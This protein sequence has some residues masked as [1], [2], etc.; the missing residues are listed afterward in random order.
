MTSIKFYNLK[1][2]YEEQKYDIMRAIHEVAIGGQYFADVSVS[3]FE[4]L[5]SKLYDRAN[6]V[7]VNSGTNALTVALKTLNLPKNSFVLIPAMTYVATANAVKAAGYEPII[8]DIDKHWLLDYNSVESYLSTGTIAA[9]IAVDLYG[10]GVD[11]LKFKHLCDYYNTKLIVDA[12]QSFEMY[13]NNYHQIDHCHALTLSFNPLKNLGAMGNAG[14]VVSKI[15]SVDQIK[16]WTVHGQLSGDVIDPGFNCRIDAIQA[17]ILNVKY[18][19]FDDNQKRKSDISNYYRHYLKGLVAM[20]ERNLE[21]THTN[22]VFPIAPKDPEPVRTALTE[23][24]IEFG[25]HYKTPIHHYSAF[26]ETK[27][28]API[29]SALANKIISL[30]NHWHL[31]NAQIEK[32]V[33]VIKSAV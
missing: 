11:L 26:K 10:Q 7:T 4:N 1:E 31:S 12:A 32:V 13:Y 6:V 9:I 14:A 20:P 3:N 5:L 25:C 27:D 28:H 2:Q 18:K 19:L 16:K 8:I 22:Y 23:A 17:A 21:C 30:P 29:A 24:N 15:Y 33:D